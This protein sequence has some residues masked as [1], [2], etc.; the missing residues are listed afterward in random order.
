MPWREVPPAAAWNSAKL[1][2]PSRLTRRDAV[3]GLTPAR[4]ARDRNEPS[5]ANG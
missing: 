2:N 4:S 1:P 5:A 3:G